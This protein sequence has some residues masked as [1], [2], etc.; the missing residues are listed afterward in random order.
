VGDTDMRHGVEIERDSLLYG[1][2]GKEKGEINSA[3]HQAIG[4]LGEGLTVNC[5]ADDGTIEGI[6][7]RERQGKSFMLGVQWHPERMYVE[8]MPDAGL[9][10]RIRDRFV[11]EIKVNKKIS[12]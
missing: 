6:E 5:R 12:R 9:Y 1:I 2:A 3:H 8:K 10:K 11:E 7:W 4:V